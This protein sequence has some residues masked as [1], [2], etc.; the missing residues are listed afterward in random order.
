[1]EQCQYHTHIGDIEESQDFCKL[2][3][4]TITEEDCKNCKEEDNEVEIL[5]ETN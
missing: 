2:E 3:G 5:E 1:M 4:I